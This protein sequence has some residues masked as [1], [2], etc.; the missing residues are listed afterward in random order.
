MCGY[1]EEGYQD[2]SNDARRN[3]SNDYRRYMSKLDRRYESHY[4]SGYSDG[5]DKFRQFP[6]WTDQQKNTYDQGYE[7]GKSDKQRN[8]SRLPARYEGQYDR[9]S[10]QYYKRGYMDGYDNRPRQYV[11]PL[12]GEIPVPLPPV[13]RR[14]FPSRRGTSTGSATWRGRV[15]NRVNII[16]KGNEISTQQVA[17][18]LITTYENLSG[19]LPRRNATVAVRKLDGRGSVFVAQ[20]PNRS[21]GYTAIVQISDP[22]RGMDSYNLQ[23]SWTAVNTL[24][25]Y[26]AGKVTWRGRVDGTVAIRVTGDSVDSID[27]T[28]SGLSSVSFETQGYLAARPG[29]VR[30]SKEDGR[31]SVYIAEQPSEAND[32]TAVIRISDPRRADDMYEIVIEW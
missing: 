4:R 27:E 15:D 19:T 2:G 5:Y 8:I 7:D 32:Y 31:G 10:E 3:I 14:N 6:E 16:I 20:Q 1:Y 26:S 22:Q 21:N 18:P 23:I 30:V 24:E 29:T 11:V 12:T 17:G 13:N 25:P 28:G 9:D